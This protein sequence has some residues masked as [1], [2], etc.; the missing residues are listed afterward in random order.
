MTEI[1]P[2]SH[3]KSIPKIDWLISL[4]VF[5][6]PSRRCFKPTKNF[7]LLHNLKKAHQLYT[8]FIWNCSKLAFSLVF[9]WKLLIFLS[10][11]CHQIC[12]HKYLFPCTNKPF[13]STTQQVFRS[14][15]DH[16]WE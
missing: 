3:E 5:I 8:F 14:S 11:K 1:F 9:T 7:Q 13:L 10:N 15:S 2:S 4:L 12:T 6:L 16:I